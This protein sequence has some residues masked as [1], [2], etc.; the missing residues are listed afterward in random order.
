[1]TGSIQP[2][3]TL[4]QGKVIGT[5]QGETAPQAI[6]AFLGVP[7]ALPP[8]GDRRFK[9]AEKV[10]PST[11]SID[12]TKFG[13][14]APGKALLAGGPKLEQSEDCLT[15]N[16]FRPTGTSEK[17]RLPVAIYLHG[18]AFNRGAAATHD[19]G[20]MVAWSKAPF[21]GVSFGY[22]IGALGFLPSTL[23]K[24]EG[25]LNLG[26]RDQVDLF[27]WVQENIEQFGGDP[28]CVTL[29]GLSAG[30]HSIGHH[31]LNYAEKPL[32]HRVILESGSPTSR[33]VRPY[34]AKIHEQQFQDYLKEVGCPSDLPES[35][36]FPFL[37]TLPSSVVTDAQ[38]KVFDK[39]NPSLRWAFQ[40]VIDDDLISRKPL[41]AWN[42]KVWNKVPIMTGFNSNEGTMYVDK[43]MSRPEQFRSFWKGLLPE[44]SEEDLDTIDCL[45]PDPSTCPD[46]PYIETRKGLG[47]GPQYKRI[48]AAYGHYAYVAPVRQTAYF[49]ALQGTPVYLYNWALPRTV[50]GRAN[51]GDNMYY[52]TF[53]SDITGLSESQKELS[54]ALHAYVTGFITSG[55]PN[56]FRG[57][58][59][60]LPEWK[61][62]VPDNAEIMIFGEGNEELIGGSTAPA[63]K[64]VKDEWAKEET[65]F[66]WSKVPISQLA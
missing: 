20:S 45:Y 53:N 10:P 35:K 12:A 23:T 6:D 37:R 54:G 52:E 14:A 26:L 21:I 30:A 46:S 33:A 48:E 22:R 1:M 16:I 58:N 17:D 61:P 65:K 32:F 55:D 42:S 5:R 15:A 25:L 8:V 27:E 31:L 49:A 13:A 59:G 7:Y 34:N 3:V 29:F 57:Q 39:Y 9:P 47:L 2:T 40:P 24:K 60:Q 38:T 36:I 63:A 66:W 56:A 44:L 28:G 64:F 19:T 51:H 43:K 50:V 11:K 41:D 62:Y 4:A 18:G